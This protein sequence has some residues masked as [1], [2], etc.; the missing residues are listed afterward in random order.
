MTTSDA[1]QAENTALRAQVESLIQ[2]RDDAL[3]AVQ[4]RQA[5]WFAASPLASIEFDNQALIRYWNPSAERIFGWSA[6]E[7]LGKN[8]FMLLVPNVAQVQVQAV[9]DALLAGQITHSR[10]P[11]IRKDSEVI[12]CQWYNALLHDRNGVVTGVLSQVEDVSAQEQAE[13][14]RLALKESVIRGQQAAL[15]EISTPLIPVAAGVV[16]MPLVGTIDSN[17]AQQI[18]E[19]LLEGISERQAYQAILDITGVRVVDTQVAQ[20]LVRT[21]QA[22]GL[23]GAQVILTGIGAEVAQ[24]LVSLG[25]DLRGI[26][27]YSTLQAGIAAVLAR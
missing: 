13:Q 15:R 4:E 10:N 12:T 6:A 17:R 22:A 2:E 16:V 5:R 23:L 8:I 1:M 25:A 9:I 19:T 21:A 27:T 7:A 24:T 26:T 11:N 18:L 20:A 14:E 3:R